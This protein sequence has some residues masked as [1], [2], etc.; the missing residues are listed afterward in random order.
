MPRKPQPVFRSPSKRKVYVSWVRDQRRLTTEWV[1]ELQTLLQSMDYDDAGHPLEKVVLGLDD[2]AGD[3]AQ[4]ALR[5]ARKDVTDLLIVGTSE[6]ILSQKHQI[7]SGTLSELL[8]F[9]QTRDSGDGSEPVLWLAPLEE[10][11]LSRYI[12]DKY[13]LAGISGWHWLR[14]DRFPLPA[15]SDDLQQ[16]AEFRQAIATALDKLL[17][18][19]RDACQDCH[20]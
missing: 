2:T 9:L 10:L 5:D 11:K 16:I 19:D 14:K 13:Q 3:V 6:Y 17:G 8:L 12:L 15:G 7:Q 1:R 18:H 20:H 4:V